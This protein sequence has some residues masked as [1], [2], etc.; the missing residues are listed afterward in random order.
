MTS[1]CRDSRAALH[2]TAVLGLYQMHVNNSMVKGEQTCP[3]ETAAMEALLRR[4]TLAWMAAMACC[5]IMKP[6]CIP[7]LHT[8]SRLVQC[9]HNQ[10][11]VTCASYMSVGE[12]R[13]PDAVTHDTLLQQLYVV[14]YVGM[15]VSK[16]VCLNIQQPQPVASVY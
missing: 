6:V 15:F 10:Y 5:R 11:G 13:C 2:K 3:T 8:A 14:M 4:S 12:L 1:V 16:C 7:Y 9:G